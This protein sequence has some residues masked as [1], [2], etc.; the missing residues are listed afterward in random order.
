MENEAKIIAAFG[1]V[2]FFRASVSVHLEKEKISHGV[3]M[4]FS[5]EVMFNVTKF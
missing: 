1:V 5:P 3:K 4:S 2:L